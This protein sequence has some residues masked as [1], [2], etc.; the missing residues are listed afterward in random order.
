MQLM[1]GLDI[2]IVSAMQVSQ[3]TSLPVDGLPNMLYLKITFS[4]RIVTQ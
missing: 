3:I 1:H 2:S 4:P